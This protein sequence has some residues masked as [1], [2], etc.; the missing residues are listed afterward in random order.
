MVEGQAS[1]PGWWEQDL[2]VEV[3]PALFKIMLHWYFIPL[4]AKLCPD[5]QAAEKAWSS[6]GRKHWSGIRRCKFY[7]Q[8]CHELLKTRVGGRGCVKTET[9]EKWQ[10]TM[11]SPCPTVLCIS[12]PLQCEKIEK[13]EFMGY[14]QLFHSIIVNSMVGIQS[15]YLQLS[16][17]TRSSSKMYW[18]S[19][20]SDGLG[21]QPYLSSRIPNPTY[22]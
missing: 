2:E 21:T 22:L 11:V 6:K 9:P 13:D 10:V 15:Y 14:F 20:C 18:G 3:H 5:L 17:Q 7:F 19:L 4:T 8:L 12:F 16:E 1:V